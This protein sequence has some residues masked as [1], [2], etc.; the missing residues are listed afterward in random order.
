MAK[1]DILNGNL[2]KTLIQLSW[3]ITIGLLMQ[4]S[5]NIIDTIFVGRL[6]ADALAAVSMTFPVIFLFVALASGIG[7]GTVALVSQNV[8]AKKKDVAALAAEQSLLISFIMGVS[9]AILGFI[10]TKPLFRIIGATEQLI[11]IITSYVYP[12]YIGILF[13]FLGFASNSI[14]RGAGDMKTPM[15]MMMIA[16]IL[17]ILFDWIF[18]FGAGPIPAMGVPGAAWATV[19]SRF[20]GFAYIFLNLL[21]VQKIIPLK[22]KHLRPNIDIIKKIFVVGIPASL[23]NIAMSLS[24]FFMIRI[25]SVFGPAAIAAYGLGFRLDSV[26]FMAIFGIAS[27]TITFVGQ[28]T[29]AKNVKRSIKATWCA[30]KMAIFVMAFLGIIFF[31]FRESIASVFTTDTEII[32]HTTNYI[33]YVSLTYGFIAVGV[34]TMSGFQGMG[35]GMPQLKMAIFRLFIFMVPLSYLFSIPMNFG[36]NG[37]WIAIATS[38]IL[39]GIVSGIWFWHDS[40]L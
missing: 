25:V 28:N 17:N 2:R 29:G 7:I 23:S 33:K 4:T 5:F 30:S 20:I 27:A 26:A 9:F 6:G 39:S 22:L 21:F 18:I 34:I 13:M 15:K 37:V 40:K 24:M 31:L 1:P 16:T 14:L 3:P 38:M 36:V 8:G 11:P 35:R 19:L 32:K 10:F 12:I